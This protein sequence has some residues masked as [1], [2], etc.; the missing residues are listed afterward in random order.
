MLGLDILSATMSN[1]DASD[2]YHDTFE[3][4]RARLPS[5]LDVH[6]SMQRISGVRRR[7]L[8]IQKEKCRSQI[9]N[10]SLNYEALLAL[11]L[12]LLTRRCL[13]R[14]QVA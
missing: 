1:F 13:V 10:G 6:S 5:F 4:G 11:A 14:T 8:T 2:T 7:K 3:P 9:Q 12:Q